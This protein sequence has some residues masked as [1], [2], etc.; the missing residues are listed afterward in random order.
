MCSSCRGACLHSARKRS[1]PSGLFRPD[2]IAHRAHP[3]SEARFTR[4]YCV[5]ASCCRM[6]VHSGHTFHSSCVRQWFE[7]KANSARSCPQCRQNPL[8]SDAEF[9]LAD[10]EREDDAAQRGER[11][12]ERHDEERWLDT[13]LYNVPGTGWFGAGYGHLEG[14][15]MTLHEVNAARGTTGR[16][17]YLV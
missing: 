9:A 11:E 14:M 16:G 7:S 13:L 12:R 4:A 3:I 8:V 5:Y 10:G 17:M 1:S 2:P 6:C 15:T